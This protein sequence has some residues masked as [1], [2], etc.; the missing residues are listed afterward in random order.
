MFHSLILQQ[1]QYRLPFIAI[2]FHHRL[3]SFHFRRA[4]CF[5]LT[6]LIWDNIHIG[7]VMGEKAVPEW[8]RGIKGRTQKEMPSIISAR[9]YFPFHFCSAFTT[10]GLSLWPL[11]TPSNAIK[12][13]KFFFFPRNKG[14][15]R[16]IV[17]CFTK[18]GEICAC[19]HVFVWRWIDRGVE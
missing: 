17:P 19:S 2:Q 6:V 14:P 9:D 5:H 11:I 16:G 10:F 3:K 18:V 1:L 12:S 7:A 13:H 4:C 8:A 15:E